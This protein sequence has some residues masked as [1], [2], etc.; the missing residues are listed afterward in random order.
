MLDDTFK[1][2]DWT[3]EAILCKV[4]FCGRYRK[5]TKMQPGTNRGLGEATAD[6]L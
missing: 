3:E 6:N 5:D 2:D 1:L 4:G